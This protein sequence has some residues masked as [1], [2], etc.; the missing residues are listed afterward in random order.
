MNGP[1]AA[2]NLSAHF[3]KAFVM[4]LHDPVPAPDCG[5]LPESEQRSFD[6]CLSSCSLLITTTESYARHLGARDP[7]VRAKIRPFHL[8]Y[9]DRIPRENEVRD[10]TNS[11]LVLLHAGWLPGG[12]GRNARDLVSGMAEACRQDPKLKGRLRMKLMGGGKGCVEAVALA[13]GIGLEGAVEALPQV[14]QEQCMYK[15]DEADVLV[16]IEVFQR[17]LRHADTGKAL[18]VSRQTKAYFGDYEGVRG[19]GDHASL[20][21]G[22]C[23]PQRGYS[24][25]RHSPPDARGEQGHAILSP[26]PRRGLYQTVLFYVS[27]RQVGRYP[28]P[29]AAGSGVPPAAGPTIVLRAAAFS[30]RREVNCGPLWGCVVLPL[31]C[32]NTR[33]R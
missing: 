33:N 32:I 15:M 20:W 13:E 1:V 4:E 23:C 31:V 7:G 30:C 17:S 21:V 26:S 3:R 25:D 6:S 22:P 28:L 8:T 12:S 29:S 11:P 24:L 18:S 19:G 2:R 5:P 9:D 10:T 16:V 14:S 27:G